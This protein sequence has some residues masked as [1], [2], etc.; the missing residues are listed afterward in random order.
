MI[1]DL[2]YIKKDISESVDV[3]SAVQT[4]WYSIVIQRSKEEIF[5]AINDSVILIPSF[6]FNTSS[7][8][9]ELLM[10]CYE[11]FFV[12]I[13]EFWTKLTTIASE[14]SLYKSVRPI[15]WEEMMMNWIFEEK[16]EELL[17]QKYA[18]VFSEFGNLLNI[19]NNIQNRVEGESD[20]LEMKE[21]QENE[22]NILWLS[23]CIIMKIL[24]EISGLYNSANKDWFKYL[25]KKDLKL[26]QIL[27]SNIIS[28]M[29][30][31]VSDLKLMRD[32]RYDDYRKNYWFIN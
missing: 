28:N 19:L 26:F 24:E 20:N 31:I 5:C 29:T 9:L 13:K 16:E 30:Q 8:K 4:L 27:L 11:E 3:P 2:N 10:S 17:M 6:D 12:K 14:I 21:K 23:I 15:D 1:Y 32:F 18:W 22:I 25:D 7:D